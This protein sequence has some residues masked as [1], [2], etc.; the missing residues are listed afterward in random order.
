MSRLLKF[1]TDMRNTSTSLSASTV[2]RGGWPV[3]IDS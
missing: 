3:S 2:I 1:A